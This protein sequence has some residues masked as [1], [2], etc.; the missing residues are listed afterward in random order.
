[1]EVGVCGQDDS[2]WGQVPIAFIKVHSDSTADVSAILEY[3]YQHLA[4]YKVPHAIYSVAELPRNSSGKLLRR[5]LH[6]LLPVGL[7]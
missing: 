1:A 7:V 4:R 5:E 6:R 2:Q 3:A